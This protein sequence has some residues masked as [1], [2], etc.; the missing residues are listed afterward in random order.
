MG[1]EI[2]WIRCKSGA[3]IVRGAGAYTPCMILRGRTYPGPCTEW[4]KTESSLYI[5][6]QASFTP[7]SNTTTIR[8]MTVAFL[9]NQRHNLCIELRTSLSNLS[10]L[11]DLFRASDVMSPVAMNSKA[12]AAKYHSSHDQPQGKSWERFCG[13][14]TPTRAGNPLPRRTKPRI[15][16]SQ[17]YAARVK[18]L[19]PTSSVSVGDFTQ[20]APL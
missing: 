14:K 2:H 6:L 16:H 9:H 13:A 8:C 11:L 4:E 7:F 1:E 15:W 3:I 5:P 18:E 17:P 10:S 19:R 12:V 20:Q